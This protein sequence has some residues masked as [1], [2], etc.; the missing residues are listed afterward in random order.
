MDSAEP[1]TG[2]QNGTLGIDDTKGN[3]LNQA[4]LE[5]ALS[6]TQALHR[7]RVVAVTRQM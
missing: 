4:G 2:M 3:E 6:C 7:S 1:C 5:S